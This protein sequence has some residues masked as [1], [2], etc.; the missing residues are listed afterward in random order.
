MAANKTTDKPSSES[1]D[2]SAV[3]PVQV[4]SQMMPAE[5]VPAP[6]FRDKVFTSRT[7]ILPDGGQARVT[8]GQISAGT[9]ELLTF[10]KAHDD[11]EPLPG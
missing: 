7:L 3:Q 5:V 4:V 10:L 11:F 9:S 1:T 2:S 8:K 6:I